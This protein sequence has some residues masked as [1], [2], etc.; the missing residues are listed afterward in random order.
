M[1]SYLALL[2]FFIFSSLAIAQSQTRIDSLL[3]AAEKLPNDTTK[4]NSLNEILNHYMYRDMDKAGATV[5]VQLTLAKQ[6]KDQS[7]IARA[8]YQMG[9]WHYNYGQADSASHYYSL[10]LTL[11]NELKDP[12]AISKA[13]NGLAIIAYYKGDLMTSDSI[14]DLDLKNT[15]QAGDS[16]GMAMAYDFKGTINQNKGY[17][18]I[19]LKYV[20]KGLKIYEQ[21]GDSVRIADCYNH[22]ATL[23]MNLKNFQKGID[24]N[25]IALKVYEAN[26]D[27][28]YQAQALNDIGVMYKLLNEEETALNYFER[29]IEKSKQANVPAL[30]AASLTNIG[31]IWIQ[32]DQPHKALNFLEQSIEISTRIGASRRI[33]IAENS[34]AEAYL[35][36][37]QP[38][39]AI[40]KAINASQYADENEN[41]SIKK[42]A[43]EH[44]AKAYKQAGDLSLALDYLTESKIL[45]DS[46]LNTNKIKTIEELRVKFELSQKEIEIELQEQELQVMK[47]H[48]ANDR[49]TKSIYA[50]GMFSFITISGLLFFGFNQ[51]IKKNRIKHEKKEALLNQELEFKKKELASQTLHLVKKNTFIQELKDNLERLKQSPE[52]FKV[53]FRRLILLLRKENAEDE[54]WE[55]FKSYFSEV[56]NNFDQ[57]LK[58]IDP[59]ITEKE[60]RL[61]SF[62]RMSLS[63]KEI[64]SIFSVMPDSVLKSKYR[65]K[66][67][68]NLD[69]E[70]DLVKYLNRI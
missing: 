69:K 43:V 52:L 24:Y 13:L 54:D 27:V 44:L 56:H 14:N 20:H 26:E 70:E 51:R 36:L 62:L 58:E 33:A 68:L 7:Q 53:E 29:S 40:E 64:A 66:Q 49:L 19:A 47:T 6:L 46:I 39:K 59:D 5:R 18:S 63:T 65:L 3:Q 9:V 17:Y 34:Q 2:L 21:L 11:A 41:V 48:A 22:L 57:K 25:L 16:V 30:Q 12:V 50:T 37:K 60:I 32:L 1:K 4:L 28:Y 55:V 61:A 38:L 31:G 45:N 8:T 15:I 35:M 10:S 67:K 42:V 23:E